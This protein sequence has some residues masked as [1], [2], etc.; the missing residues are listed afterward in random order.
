MTFGTWMFALALLIVVGGALAFY[1]SRDRLPSDWPVASRPIM[2]VEEQQL[3]ERLRHLLP[4]HMVLAKVP[5]SRFM[6]LRSDKNASMWFGVLNPLH[7]TFVICAPDR[8]VVTAIDLETKS[9]RSEQA[10]V[11]KAKALRT[12]G[13]SYIT[14]PLMGL[15]TDE[16]L[17]AE[18]LAPMRAERDPRSSSGEPGEFGESVFGAD[19]PQADAIRERIESLRRE[20]EKQRSVRPSSAAPDSF[21]RND[22]SRL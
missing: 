15:G 2:A 3:F 18:L 12:C 9:G 16:Q 22:D 5:L 21:I 20:R 11:L 13:I 6:R 17:R 4:D 14:L 8:R 10:H 1:F 19:Q 7:V